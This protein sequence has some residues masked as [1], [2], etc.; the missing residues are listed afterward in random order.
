MDLEVFSLH[1]LT[2]RV[3]KEISDCFLWRLNWLLLNRESKCFYGWYDR[4][5][6]VCLT[7]GFHGLSQW[8]IASRLNSRVWR[9]VFPSGEIWETPAPF[10]C[11]DSLMGS[12]DLV[13]IYHAGGTHPSWCRLLPSYGQSSRRLVLRGWVCFLCHW[14]SLLLKTCDKPRGLLMGLVCVLLHLDQRLGWAWF[15]WKLV[16]LLVPYISFCPVPV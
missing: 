16:Y 3:D 9:S 12:V 8:L 5:I 10:L 6:S 15:G 7:A 4:D 14:P 11:C 13:W 1:P 2:S